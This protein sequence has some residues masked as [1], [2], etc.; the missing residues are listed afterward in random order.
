M[1]KTFTAM[2][3]LSML[4]AVQA[5]AAFQYNKTTPSKGSNNVIEGYF[6]FTSNTEIAIQ[7]LEGYI[8]THGGETDAPVAEAIEWGYYNMETPGTLVAAKPDGLLGTFAS[9]DQ[10]GI[11]VKDA[12]GQAYTSTDTRVAGYFFDTVEY[13]SSNQG[14]NAHAGDDIFCIFNGNS[15]HPNGNSTSWLPS[16]YEYTIV[17][18]EAKGQPL[19]GTLLSIAAATAAIVA[20]RRR[21]RV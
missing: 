15:F 6:S 5:F 4:C 16:H 8:G 17:A 9:G 14:A 13:H 21:K 10:I 19:P 1:E 11:Y 18:T 7:A 3:A 12:N 2:A 20:F